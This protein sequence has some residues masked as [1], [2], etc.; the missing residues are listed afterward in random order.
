MRKTVAK[1]IYLATKVTHS[2]RMDQVRSD[3]M[4]FARYYA[5]V[6]GVTGISASFDWSTDTGA[7]ISIRN[8]D[9]YPEMLAMFPMADDGYGALVFDAADG[10]GFSARPSAPSERG[11]GFQDQKLS[12][13]AMD[14]RSRIISNVGMPAL[15]NPVLGCHIPMKSFTCTA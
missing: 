13:A 8:M 14:I 15:T 2:T 6:A 11:F 3:A 4:C 5:G 9:R 7:L 12:T 1:A 10:S